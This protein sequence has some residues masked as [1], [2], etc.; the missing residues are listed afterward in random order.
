M[1][2][3]AWSYTLAVATFLGEDVGD[4]QRLILMLGE[5]ANPEADRY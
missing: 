4:L 3:K 1:W 2:Q 5:S